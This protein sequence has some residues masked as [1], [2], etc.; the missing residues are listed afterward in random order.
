MVPGAASKASDAPPIATMRALPGVDRSSTIVFLLTSHMPC[1]RQNSLTTGVMKFQEIVPAVN[2]RMRVSA[3][4]VL[5]V[6][7][8]N[9]KKRKEKTTPVGVS[10]MR[11]QVVYRAAQG[12][13]WQCVLAATAPDMQLMKVLTYFCEPVFQS[14]L[15]S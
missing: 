10:L 7:Q 8:A 9:G 14:C 4:C 12:S 15:T 5:F 1:M 11:S 2:Y 6:P 13:K 3:A